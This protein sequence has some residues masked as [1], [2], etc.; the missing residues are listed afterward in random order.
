MPRWIVV[1][2]DKKEEEA[3]K[4]RKERFEEHF[5]FLRSNFHA[6][7]F[8]CGLKATFEQASAPYGGLWMVE[9]DSRA[10]VVILLEQDPYFKLGL[11]EAIDI[12][13]AHEG[14]V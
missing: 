10:D 13:E 3:R 1:L 8:S 12:Y 5:A 11:R 7:V 2:R 6:I 9:A 14:Y 4:I